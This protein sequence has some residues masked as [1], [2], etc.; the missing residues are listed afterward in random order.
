LDALLELVVTSKGNSNNRAYQNP[1]K[2]LIPQYI[3][4]PDSAF[5][6]ILFLTWIEPDYSAT[7]EGKMGA[8]L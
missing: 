3:P 4:G 1:R 5:L 7:P 8:S 6:G 2:Q